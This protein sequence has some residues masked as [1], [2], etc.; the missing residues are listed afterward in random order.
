MVGEA[1][2]SPQDREQQDPTDDDTDGGDATEDDSTSGSKQLT[3]NAGLERTEFVRC[4]DEDS[5]N[6]HDSTA[7]R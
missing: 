2:I 6:G 7:R 1:V 5:F 4:P 3:S